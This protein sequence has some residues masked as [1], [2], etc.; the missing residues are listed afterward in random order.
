M[1]SSLSFWRKKRG[2]NQIS[3]GRQIGVEQSMVSMFENGDRE[4][5]PEIWEK[6]SQV[7]SVPVDVF[8]SPPP[9]QFGL[10]SELTI[11]QTTSVPSVP[12][13][14]KGK[15]KKAKRVPN[16]FGSINFLTSS[17]ARVCVQL[18]KTIKLTDEE[19][20]GVEVRVELPCEDDDV[21][22]QETK[23]LAAR[24]AGDF[25]HQEIK[26]IEQEWII[27]HNGQQV[28]RVEEMDAREESGFSENN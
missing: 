7:L 9:I 21:A 22:I 15:S 11:E 24:Y 27:E 3:L 28:E 12:G 4:P 17:Q 14:E 6:I 18:R 1:K 20:D 26:R 2:I 23:A 19:W 13:E 16:G 10:G 25:V 8:F 5:T